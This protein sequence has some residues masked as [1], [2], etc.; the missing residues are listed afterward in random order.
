MKNITKSQLRTGMTVKL[1]GY[2]GLAKVVFGMFG[3]VPQGSLIGSNGEHHTNFD[4][5]DDNLNRI[6][7]EYTEYTIE[8]IWDVPKRFQDFGKPCT[9]PLVFSREV[10]MTIA[11]IEKALGITNL[12]VVK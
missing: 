2:E 4:T 9:D 10:E 11:E 5:Y 3:S 7:K 1:K 6:S 8:K 12:K